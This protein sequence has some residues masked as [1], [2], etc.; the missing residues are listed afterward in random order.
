MKK[1]FIIGFILI[2]FVFGL[3]GCNEQ[4]T[5]EN[6][7]VKINYE[8]MQKF[9]GLWLNESPIF[10]EYYLVTED[11]RIY[12]LDEEQGQ[13]LINDYDYLPKIILDINSYEKYR[14]VDGYYEL[15]DFENEKFFRYATYRFEVDNNIFIFNVIN[16]GE[17]MYSRVEIDK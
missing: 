16:N 17:V 3:N 2:I 8:D 14:F 11:D 9:V 1:K 13:L 5:D 7:N 12:I 10:V 4:K 6:R 15:Y